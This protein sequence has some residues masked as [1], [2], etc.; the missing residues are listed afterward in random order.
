MATIKVKI[1]AAGAPATLGYGELGIAS[2]ELYFGDSGG[3][4]VKLSIS[5]HTHAYSLVNLN[6]TAAT[7]STATFFAPTTGA[8]TGNY[9]LFSGGTNA[10]PV[11]GSTVLGSMAYAATTSYSYVTLNGTGSTNPSFYAPATGGTSTIYLLQGAASGAPTWTTSPSI[12]SLTTSGTITSGSTLSVGTGSTVWTLN[13]SSTT[14]FTFTRSTSTISLPVVAGT[15]NIADTTTTASRILLSTSTAGQAIWS[16]T[17]IGTMAYQASTSFSTTAHVQS[18]TYGGTGTTSYAIGDILYASATNALS[19]LASVTAGYFL[20]T[21]G[22]GTA[23]TWAINYRPTVS[24]STTAT[25][26]TPTY[27]TAIYFVGGTTYSI[28]L[29]STAFS[30]GAEII[31][32]KTSATTNTVTITIPA[33]GTIN[34]TSGGSTTLTTQYSSKRFYNS[35]AATWYWV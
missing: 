9:P 14:A 6:G 24:L 5:S 26:S 3:V 8:T 31:F 12:T 29:S 17:T 28:T 21:A 15:I 11:W 4:P 2:N 23:P 30:A 13:G 34:G 7:N 18:A 20:K 16:T 32:I 1:A 22:A 35:A 33:T 25:I 27:A 10:A 19:K